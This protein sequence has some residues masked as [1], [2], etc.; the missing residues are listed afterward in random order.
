MNKTMN[1]IT[2]EISETDG[3]KIQV[4][5]EGFDNESLPVSAVANHLLE[6]IINATEPTLRP[7]RTYIYGAK[8]DGRELLT[9]GAARPP[10]HG[11]HDAQDIFSVISHAETLHTEGMPTFLNWLTR[12]L[13]NRGMEVGHLTIG[14]LSQEILTYK[15]LNN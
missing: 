13:K 15:N 9:V 12:R 8:R 7:S 1:K 3:G 2:I 10:Q 4:I 6:T 11:K 14:E 5:F